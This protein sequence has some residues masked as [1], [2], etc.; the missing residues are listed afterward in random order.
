MKRILDQDLKKLILNLF[1]EFGNLFSCISHSQ[2]HLLK[3][4]IR[5]SVLMTDV[6]DNNYHQKVLNSCNGHQHCKCIRTDG[7]R[8]FMKLYLK[9]KQFIF[10]LQITKVIKKHFWV[11]TCCKNLCEELGISLFHI[12][13]MTTGS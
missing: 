1:K 9:R 3:F 4:T 5:H 6:F 8:T 12:I 10:L 2:S 7:L 13:C 11:Q